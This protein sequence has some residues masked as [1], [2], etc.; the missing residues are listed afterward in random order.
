[1]NPL[2][3]TLPVTGRTRLRRKPARGVFDRDAVYRILDEAFLCHLAFVDDGQPYC[4]PTAYARIGDEVYVHGSAASRT[5]RALGGA[6]ELCLTVTLLD[7]LVLAR[8]GFNHSMNYRSVMVLGR[9]R[10][11]TVGAE[12]LRAL[13]AITDHIVPGRWDELRPTSE[14]ELKSTAVLALPIVEASAKVRSGPPLDADEASW[15]VWAGV[16]PIVTS[17][18]TPVPAPEMAADAPPFDTTIFAGRRPRA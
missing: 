6:I 7:G 17:Y 2:P 13:A 4:I 11:V 18:A 15:P 8:S 5:A 10:E 3:S 12:K 9:A 1:M 16:V 14:Q